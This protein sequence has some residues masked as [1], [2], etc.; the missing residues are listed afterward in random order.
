M[1]ERALVVYRDD[2]PLARALGAAAAPLRL[3]PLMLILA[4]VL[5]AALAAA[6]GPSRPLAAAAI[7]WLVL[8]AGLSGG[9]VGESRLCWAVPPALRAAEY[10][11]LL[12]LAGSAHAA[13]AFAL[14]AAI[15]LHQYDLVYGLQYR[16]TAP[17][18][19]LSAATGGWD[20]RLLLAC[21]LLLA[22]ALGPGL[23]IA[24]ALLALITVGQSVT[25]WSAAGEGDAR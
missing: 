9:R 21:V 23:F 19:W 8:I 15:A 25:G 7:C 18:R 5:P 20:G 16:G 12:W 14:L 10:A 4:G 11:S 17:T 1:T 24:G 2:G 3:P 6:A 22:G 13:A